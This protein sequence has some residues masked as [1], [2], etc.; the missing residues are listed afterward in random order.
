MA[1]WPNSRAGATQSI[2]VWDHALMLQQD[3]FHHQHGEDPGMLLI[4]SSAAGLGKLS[5]FW[6]VPAPAS[7]LAQH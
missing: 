3:L 5:H 1:L 2:Q 6:C 7:M 4:N